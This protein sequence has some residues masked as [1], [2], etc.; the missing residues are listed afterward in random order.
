MLAVVGLMPQFGSL[1]FLVN[2]FC[3]FCLPLYIFYA[4]GVLEPL[5]FDP[6]LKLTGTINDKAVNVH[7]G[8]SSNLLPSVARDYVLA[9]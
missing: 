8:M 5:F 9:N 7:R 6:S 1:S 4:D 2:L 3:S